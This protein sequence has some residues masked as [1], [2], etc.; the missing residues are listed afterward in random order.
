MERMLDYKGRI[1]IPAEEDIKG[2]S[3]CNRCWKDMPFCWE[4]VCHRCNYTFCYNCSILVN[5]HW[6]CKNCATYTE[7]IKNFLIRLCEY[8]NDRLV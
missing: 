3:V 7:R 8:I 5:S 4:T 1:R 6:T 2:H